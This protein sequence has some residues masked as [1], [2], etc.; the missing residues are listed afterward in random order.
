MFLYFLTHTRKIAPTGFMT[1][2]WLGPPG[3]GGFLQA[4]AEFAGVSRGAAARTTVCAKKYD[5]RIEP[6]APGLR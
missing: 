2:E 4:G 6:G 5:G 3:T 1:F